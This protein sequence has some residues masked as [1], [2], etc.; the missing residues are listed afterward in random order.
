[1]A[2]RPK[3]GRHHLPA[4][5]RY[6]NSQRI[7]RD[8][9]LLGENETMVHSVQ[10]LRI[11]RGKIGNRLPISLIVVDGVL[12]SPSATLLN[13]KDLE[14]ALKDDGFSL[15]S[16]EFEG[17]GVIVTLSRASRGPQK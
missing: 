14:D 8:L 1:M 6:E 3:F 4:K 15:T 17:G 11:P 10:S 2:E 16:T 7:S 12:V 13:P 5:P 9:G